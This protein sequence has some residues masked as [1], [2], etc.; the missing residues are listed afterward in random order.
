MTSNEIFRDFQKEHP[1]R[2]PGSAAAKSLIAQIVE[3]TSALGLK[4]TTRQIPV[5]HLTISIWV[6]I[7]GSLLASVL[8][9]FIPVAGLL[10]AV[11][12]WLLLIIEPVGPLLARIKPSQAENA[13]LTIP[14]RS[15]ETRKVILIA[16]L[17][18]DSFAPG[19]AKPASRT[20]LASVAGLGLFEIL[21]LFAAMA[22]GQRFISLL[23]ILPLFG[24]AVFTIL[25]NENH[26][27]SSLQ[28]TSLLL[29][30]GS[31]LWKAGASTTSVVLYFA[32]ANSLNSGVL[33]LKRLTKNGPEQQ[34]VIDLIDW[35]DKRI[36][37]VSTDGFLL[38]RQSDPLLVELFMEVA[39]EKGIPLQTIKLSE[40]S[41]TY[42]LKCKKLK[43]IAV[44]NPLETAESEKNLRELL[45]G[46]IRKLD[47]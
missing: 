17:T 21:I 38:P 36:N 8:S 14:A 18:T 43:A 28:N 26:Q 44:T 7:T 11:I 40:L 19:P 13:F 23:A 15:K 10:L 32:G 4:A 42:L 5:F 45:I 12:L 46:I 1:E 24:L 33:D 31:I 6:F 37:L 34:Y 3:Q 30:L 20:F 2:T 9:L 39:R 47:Y 29:E 27:N 41:S 25:T 35:P 22:A 16:H